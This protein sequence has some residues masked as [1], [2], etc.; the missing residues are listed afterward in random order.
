[1]KKFAL[2]F[3]NNS[4]PIALALSGGRDSMCLAHLFLENGVNFFAVNFEHGI[5]GENS[6]KD[7][8]FVK[9]WCDA[10]GVK[11]LSYAF[12][13]PSF[14]KENGLT[15]E[16]AGRELRYAHF[17]KLIDENKCSY[18]A[19]AHHASDNAETVLMRI[20]RG[21]GVKGLVGMSA[22]NGRYI[23]PLIDWSRDDIDEYVRENN[24]P[25]VD[26]ETNCDLKYSRNFVRDE[27][28]RIKE[29]Y[30]TV[31]QSLLR[32]SRNAL[33][34][35]EFVDSLCDFVPIL[36]ENE[37]KI[38]IEEL[39]AMPV[40][41]AKRAILRACECLGITQDIEEKHFGFIFALTD[42]E[43]GKFIELT[44]DIKVHKDGEYL[45]FSKGE[46]NAIENEIPFDGTSIDGII[47][48]EEVEH[49]CADGA[50]YI[51]KNKL[52]STAVLRGIK[53]FDKIAKFGGGTK[54]LGD[55]L[56]DKKIPLR[57]RK[58]LIV[59]AADKQGTPREHEI[60]F[61]LGVEISSTLK[62]ENDDKVIKITKE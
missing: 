39:N 1:M 32:L 60:L 30:P 19:L 43:N 57:K 15:I 28:K 59:C 26:D 49:Y 62:V 16:Q 14:A 37:V 50:L 4:L 23:R 3:E 33:E 12:D 46:E 10:N 31:E 34:A 21:T 5:R 7:S 58:S 9:N 29:K 47:K 22:I 27:I 8:E 61:V 51:S 48:A 52:P 38:G 45:V 25:F 13:T 24:V 17:Q 53:E 2:D 6:K 20:F 36:A 44:H 42:A 41:I 40:I 55:F 54:N 18:V 56:T 11:L 35:D